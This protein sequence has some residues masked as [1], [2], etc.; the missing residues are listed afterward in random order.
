MLEKIDIYI[1]SILLILY[2]IIN[3]Y[4]LYFLLIYIL[5]SLYYIYYIYKYISIGFKNNNKIIINFI[6]F[7]L[8][9][10]FV[11]YFVI[12]DPNPFYYILTVYLPF[13]NLFKAIFIYLFHSY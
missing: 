1:L 9:D 13:Q 10:F 2:I 7:S 12:C 3:D 8:F 6:A 5:L 11:S 4:H